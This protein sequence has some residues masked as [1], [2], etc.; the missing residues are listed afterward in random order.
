M[1]S[2]GAGQWTAGLATPLVEKHT[3]NNNS[4]FL[5]AFCDSPVS[6]PGSR[7]DERRQ[8]RPGNNPSNTLPP[9]FRVGGGAF[10]PASSTE[11]ES[12]QH[13]KRKAPT[14]RARVNSPILTIKTLVAPLKNMSENCNA[15]PGSQAKICRAGQNKLPSSETRGAFDQSLQNLEII[16]PIPYAHFLWPASLCGRNGMAH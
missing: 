11:D 8:A 5:Q 16:C 10:L 6:G 7:G 3:R 14:P 15:F 1:P 12:P 13:A 2:Q 4:C 9:T